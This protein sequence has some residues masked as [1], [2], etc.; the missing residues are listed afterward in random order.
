M[1]DQEQ[2]L[3]RMRELVDKLPPP[4]TAL[5]L[6]A[7][8]GIHYVTEGGECMGVCLFNVPR[9]A[10][11]RAFMSEGARL[12]IHTHDGK[13]VLVLY[14]GALTV[15]VGAETRKYG[16]GDVIEF[17]AHTAHVVAAQTD[18]WMI[19][20]TIPADEGYPRGPTVFDK[21]QKGEA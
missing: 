12:P 21:K 4:L 1:S 11:Q 8:A 2:N 14:A 3:E 9:V 6:E 18:T 7:V 20:V 17:V 13:E 15:T 10:V 5:A 16:A 19:A